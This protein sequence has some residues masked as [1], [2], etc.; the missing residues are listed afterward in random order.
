MLFV[1]T[2]V[3]IPA[4]AIFTPVDIHKYPDNMTMVI[5]LKNGGQTVDTCEVAAF[6]GDECRGAAR[7][8]KSLYY[9]VVSGEGGGQQMEIRTCLDG[10]IVT[11]DSSIV[12]SG[13]QNIGTP[14]EPYVIDISQA[15]G[16]K[17]KKGDC[18]AD[19]AVDVADIATVITVMAQ[20]TEASADKRRNADVNGDGSVDVADIANIISIM[21]AGARAL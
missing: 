2:L 7:A 3:A 16:A 21:S 9:L 15:A 4:R 20:G 12:Y 6:V 17:R 19:G 11:I 5:Q 13:D 18:N 8:T 10:E 14:W 1:L